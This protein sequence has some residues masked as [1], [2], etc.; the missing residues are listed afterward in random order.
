MSDA[1]DQ[2]IS[3]FIKRAE[4]NTGLAGQHAKGREYD[5]ALK[6]YKEAYG[7]IMKANQAKPDDIAIKQ[8]ME[9]IKAKYQ[10]I[11]K[12]VESTKK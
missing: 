11:K 7:F 6:L 1:N 3:F 2:A 12:L 4:Y 5:K 8:K 9:D 10:E